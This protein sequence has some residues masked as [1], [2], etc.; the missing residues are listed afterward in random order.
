MLQ[1]KSVALIIL[2]ALALAAAGVTHSYILLLNV[3]VLSFLMLSYAAKK[4][5]LKGTV[6]LTGVISLVLCIPYI[7]RLHPQPPSTVELW[8]F[9]VWYAE[10]SIRS[11]SDLVRVIPV[12]SPLLLFFGILGS[13][14][15]RKNVIILSWLLAVLLIPLLSF[16]QITYPGWYTISPNRILFHVFAPFCILSGTFFADAEKL[17]LKKKFLFF[18]FLIT[19]FSGGMHH[20]NLFNSF[21]PDPVS[22]V[23]MNPDDAFVMQWI[24]DSTSEDTVVLNTG[25][26]VDCS[27]WIPVICKRKVVFPSFSGHRGDSCIEKV[28][29]HR[30]RVDLKIIEYAPDSDTALQTLRTYNIAYVYVPAWKKRQYLEVSPESLIESPLYHPVVTKG[31]AYLFRVN[32]DEKPE[33]AFFAVMDNE[34]IAMEGDNLFQVSFSPFLSEDFQGAFFLYVEYTDNSY[35][36][37]DIH[38]DARYIGTILKYKTGEEKSMI[39]PLFNSDTIN[40]FFYPEVDFFLERM[41]ILCGVEQTIWISDHIGLKGNWVIPAPGS[42][43]VSAPAEDTGLRIYLFNVYGG[44]L[45]VHYEDTG[46]GNVDINI[47]DIRGRWNTTK[48][49]HRENSGDIKEVHIGVDDYSVLVIGVYVYGEDFTIAALQYETPQ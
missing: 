36:Q 40:L 26:T 24:T 15:L 39:Y 1:K 34:Q 12:L 5:G 14:N 23:Q 4:E 47:L 44:E 49:I 11:L 43:R 46:Y 16:F 6:L 3:L 10:D 42:D 35:G 7:I 21:L 25:P 31:D 18:M 17:L 32:Y 19:L 33:T 48:I 38:Q 30:K 37:I 29:A 13:C 9:T 2:S 22:D 27:S 8:T 20:L 41:T 28:G 45:I